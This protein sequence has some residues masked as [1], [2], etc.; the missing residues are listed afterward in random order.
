[1]TGNFYNLNC[2]NTIQ[3]FLGMMAGANMSGDLRDPSSAIPKGT[4]WGILVTT[5][6]YALTM[7]IT[8][9]ATVRDADGKTMPI[10]NY[11]AGTYEKPD[12]FYNGGCKYGLA[13]DFNVSEIIQ[14]VPTGRSDLFCL[15]L[16]I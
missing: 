12:C 8:S 3:T 14:G 4:L 16:F 9:A 13:N 11:S 15:Y 7:I 10:F 2:I 6:A 5:I 1:M